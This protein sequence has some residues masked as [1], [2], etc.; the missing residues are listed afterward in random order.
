MKLKT[1]LLLVILCGIALGAQAQQ[2]DSTA[3]KSRTV[4]IF[5][6][7]RIDYLQRIYSIR[8]NVKG[9]LKKVFRV[10]I[11][12]TTSRESVNKSKSDFASKFPGVPVY[13]SFEPPTFKLRAG[14]F[15]TR[16]DAQSFLREVK[17]VF[18]AS[19]IVEQ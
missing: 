14:N 17:E 4:L 18:P 5:K 19:F 2:A 9:E 16:Q 6:D 15:A 7:P 8:K 3:S 1:L 12:A 10:Q 11:S 13:L